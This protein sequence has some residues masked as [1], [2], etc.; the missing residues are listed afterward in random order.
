MAIPSQLL[1][2]YLRIEK[3]YSIN[4]NE[5]P[6]FDLPSSLVLERLE[7]IPP[8]EEQI[9]QMARDKL[10]VAFNKR[11]DDINEKYQKKLDDIAVKRQVAQ[12]KAQL[13]KQNVQSGLEQKIID[14][15]FDMMR[16]G[17]L[18]SSIRDELVE[19]ARAD[20][21]SQNTSADWVLQLTLNELQLQ[22]QNATEQKELA[23]TNLQQNYDVE[24][25]Q[26]VAEIKESVAKKV[27]NTAKY[28]NTQKEKESDYKRNWHSAYIDAKQAHA[29]MARTLLTVSINEGYEVIAEYI[30]QDKATFTK[31]YYLG[32]SASDAYNQIVSLAQDY[33]THMGETHYN[34]LVSFFRSRL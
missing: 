15:D 2:Q 5:E 14:I 29:E 23:L 34:E 17:L 32:F 6:F 33:K 27:E 26:E 11:R 1:Q 20:A 19:K 31:D 7:Y 9:S 18:Q 4:P 22:E 21:T 24:F 3:R 10:I 25:A 12:N 8:T 16:R 13:D 28:N 30:R